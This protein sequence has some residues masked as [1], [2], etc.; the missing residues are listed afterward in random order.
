MVWCRYLGHVL[1]LFGGF[2]E[3]VEL[4]AGSYGD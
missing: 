2:T 1:L 4:Q 3:I